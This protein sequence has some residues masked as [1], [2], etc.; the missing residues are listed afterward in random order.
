MI[1]V[2][3]YKYVNINEITFV[4]NQIYCNGGLLMF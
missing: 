3:F 2:Y 4:N 1:R